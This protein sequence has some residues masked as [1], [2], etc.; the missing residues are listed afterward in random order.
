MKKFILFATIPVLLFSCEKNTDTPADPV[1]DQPGLTNWYKFSGNYNEVKGKTAATT[2][3]TPSFTTDRKG[4]PNS[5]LNL[6]G[7][8]KVT[9]GKVSLAKNSFSL[10]IWIAKGEADMANHVSFVDIGN[11]A[12]NQEDNLIAGAVSIPST[13][14]VVTGCPDFNWHHY[15]VTYDG[16]DIRLYVDGAF[17][18]VTNHPG[19]A[20]SFDV[21]MIL[22]YNGALY[23][24]GK[25][26]EIKIFN[27]LLTAEEILQ[28]S[29]E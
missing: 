8:S 12:M 6:D 13:K 24:K 15:V 20:S 11:L 2:A 18:T 1:Q 14:A 25:L 29:K 17:K 3:G 26:D 27:K 21:N 23:W 5:A 16:T 9:I 19:N 10:S 22:G 7:G 4:N 28:L